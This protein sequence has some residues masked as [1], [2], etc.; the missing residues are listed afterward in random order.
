M[1]PGAEAIADVSAP[2]AASDDA[3]VSENPD[4]AALDASLDCGPDSGGPFLTYS[5]PCLFVDGLSE[6]FD[7]GHVGQ[8]C[9][10]VDACVLNG[11]TPLRIADVFSVADLRCSGDDRGCTCSSYRS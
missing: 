9:D 5:G 10:P 2:S 6:E 8:T 4:D 3:T 7:A 1:A 11:T